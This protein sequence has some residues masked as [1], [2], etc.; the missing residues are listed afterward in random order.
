MVFDASPI[1]LWDAWQFAATEATL[2]LRIW[3]TAPSDDKSQA[4]TAYL[5]ALDREQQAALVL[6][7]RLRVHD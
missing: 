1:E 3:F 6:G 4:H 5:A 7:K 2:K